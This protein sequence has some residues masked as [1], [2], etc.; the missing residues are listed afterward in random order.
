MDHIIRD[1][2]E[3]HHP[4]YNDKAWDKM[5]QMLDKHLPQ[6]KDNRKYIFFLLIFLLLGG[7]ALYSI[8]QFSQ[9]DDKPATVADIKPVPGKSSSTGTT[10]GTPAN[11]PVAENESAGKI[12]ASGDQDAQANGRS[13][14][15]QPANAKDA[16]AAPGDADAAAVPAQGLSGAGDEKNTTSANVKR[17]TRVGKS[18]S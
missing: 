5:E 6:K 10:S 14:K 17:N 9:G 4:P 13:G 11:D 3:N 16:T 7:G 1:A 15:A 18:R 2:A 12:T 8:Y